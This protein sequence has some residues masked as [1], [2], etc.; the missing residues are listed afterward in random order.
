MARTIS[1]R[2]S[3]PDSGHDLYHGPLYRMVIPM[4]NYLENLSLL[5]TTDT[6][7]SVDELL[8]LLSDRDVRITVA[9][10]YDHPNATL[11]ELATVIVGKTAVDESRIGTESDYQRACVH[12]YHSVLPR[13]DDHDL[14][15]FDHDEKAV[16]DVDVPPVV[17]TVLGIEE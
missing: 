5:S 8:R 12:L 17:F 15:E 7:R 10:L 3:R 11:D 1:I 6:D 13:L 14:L 2:Y 4:D 16:R 9:Y